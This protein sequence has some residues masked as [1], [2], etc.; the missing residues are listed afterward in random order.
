[1][2]RPQNFFLMLNED[3]K[4]EMY[5][6]ASEWR[7]GYDADMALTLIPTLTD[8]ERELIATDK[9]ISAIKSVRS[10]TGQ[11]LYYCKLRCDMYKK[12]GT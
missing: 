1:M 2:S 6:L 11:G 12:T 10:R 3:E 4:Q 5:K 7:S 8:T 9:P